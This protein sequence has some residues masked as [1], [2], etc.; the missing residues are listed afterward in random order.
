MQIELPRDQV[1]AGFANYDKGRMV[2]HTSLRLATVTLRWSPRGLASDEEVAT[3][4]ASLTDPSQGPPREADS[5]AAIPVPAGLEG[6]SFRV[7]TAGRPSEMVITS[8]VVCGRRLISLATAGAVRGVQSLH[9]RMLASLRCEPDAAEEATL[10][11]RPASPNPFP[12]MS[13]RKPGL[14][15]RATNVQRALD[16]LRS[17]VIPG[18]PAL[19]LPPPGGEAQRNRRRTARS[20]TDPCT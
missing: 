1:F 17:L 6:R 18:A 10:N 13:R 5:L 4:M 8:Y 11:P 16:P 20:P 12:W 14:G 19:K 15:Y 9:E 3:A 7:R 2:I